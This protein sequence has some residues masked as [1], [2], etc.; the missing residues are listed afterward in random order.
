MVPTMLWRT[1]APKSNL[2]L[3]TTFWLAMTVI[4]CFT[5]G[6]CW[7]FGKSYFEEV[8]GQWVRV[9]FKLVVVWFGI[10][11]TSLARCTSNDFLARQRKLELGVFS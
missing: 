8:L 7:R 3:F 4:A 5:R 6:W 1:F 11:F 10:G 2:A 9:S